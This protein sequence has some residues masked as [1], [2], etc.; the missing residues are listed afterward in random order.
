MFETQG[1][2]VIYAQWSQEDTIFDSCC[3]LPVIS[4]I[5]LLMVGLAQIMTIF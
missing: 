1:S 5:M 4:E 2:V 3:D